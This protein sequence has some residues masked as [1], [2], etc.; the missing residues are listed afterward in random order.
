MAIN[1]AISARRIDISGVVQG[2]GFRPFLFQLAHGYGFKG[3][4][5]NTGQG[6]TLVVEGPDERMGAFCRDITEK[7]PP[8]AAVSHVKWVP[9]TV[10]GFE[11]FTICTSHGGEGDRRVLISPDVSVCQDCLEE[12]HDPANRRFAYPFI[13]CTHCGPRYT[14]IKDV[15]YDRPHTA[16]A[17]FSLCPA[18]QR[19]YDDPLDRR[20][21]AQPNACPVCGPQVF[22]V[23]RRGN[24]VGEGPG[25]AIE[26]AACLLKQGHIVAVKGLGG[27]HLAV[28]ATCHGGVSR[29]RKGKQRPDKPFALMALSHR[30]VARYVRISPGEKRVLYSRHRPIVILEKQRFFHDTG[31]GGHEFNHPFPTDP[32]SLADH[33]SLSDAI[34]PGND[35]LGIML[36]YTPL[37]YLLLEKGP[38][39]LVMTSGNPSG[40]PLS[41]DNDEALSVFSHL[42]DYFL[43]HNRDIYFRADDSIVQ[44]QGEVPRFFRRS[45]G[46]APLPVFLKQAMPQVLACGGGLKSTVCLTRENKAFLSQHIG[47]LDNEK[48]FQFYLASVDHLRR[49]LGI[50]PEI[51]AHDLHPGYL[52]SAWAREQQ[53]MTRVA[54]QHHHAHAV[55]CMAENGIVDQVIAITLD[56]TG[57]GTDGAI[58]GGEVLTCTLTDFKRRAHLKYVPMPG[59]DAAVREP[60]RMAAAFLW[61]VWG[62]DFLDLDLPLIHRVG[63]DRLSFVAK[64]MEKEV[65]SPLTSSCGRLFDAVASLGGIRDKMTFEGQAAMDLQ[66]VSKRDG[67]PP[68][69]M[70]FKEI[71]DG[72]GKVMVEMDPCPVIREMVEDVQ[73]GRSLGEMGGR[74]HETVIQGFSLAALK[75]RDSTGIN[76]VVL[77]GGVFNNGLILT[78]ILKRLENMGMRVY[79]HGKVPAGDGGISLGQA[80]IAGTSARKK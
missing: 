62:M 34:A 17:V 13:N 8:L 14:I 24:R 68:Y 3:Q 52:S 58:W 72:A 4:V 42:A 51:I 53:G 32:V 41:I 16:M 56:G 67:A 10:Q 60:W 64:M 78:G 80:V 74:F 22:L 20:F 75:V 15:P 18:C 9:V 50:R 30:D 77:S 5:S 48:V 47:D 6:V 27:F 38:P 73:K 39:V 70:C 61:Q 35:C 2:V 25:D 33:V 26:T 66:A 54:V 11:T 76:Q 31:V 7:S 79:T 49:I 69:G 65:N 45:R 36:P 55:S 59:G 1:P 43:L 57:L 23:D 29:L 63:R 19:E 40:E 44:V 28:D 21:H 37:H 71:S 46:Y 12:L